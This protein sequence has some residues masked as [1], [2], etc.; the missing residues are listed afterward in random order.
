M[1]AIGVI[2]GLAVVV[3]AAGFLAPEHFLPETHPDKV[4]RIHHAW[5]TGHGIG[6]WTVQSCENI[7]VNFQGHPVIF[8]DKTMQVMSPEHD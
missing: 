7:V 4:P 6:S 1:T 2:L 8:A 3:I 5:D